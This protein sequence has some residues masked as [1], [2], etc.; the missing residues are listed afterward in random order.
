MTTYLIRRLLQGILILFIVTVLVFVVMRLLP[1]DPLSLYVSQKDIGQ[2]T[3]EQIEELHH[4]FGLDKPIPM[5]Y[6]SWINGVF[7]GDLG[8]SIY[9]NQQRVSY[10]ISSRLPITIHIGVIS[11]IITSV[12]GVL[13]GIVCALRRGGWIDNVVTF[14]A[15]V[16]ITVPTFWVGILLIYF[17]AMQLKWLPTTGY[18]S[19]FD[20]FWLGTKQLIMPVFCLSIPGIAGLTRQ[21]RSS[22]LEVVMQDYV[23]TAWAK[24]L[25]E[26]I[27]VLRHEVKNALIPVIT[28]LGMQVG[29]IFGGSV[30]IETVYNIP[31]MGRLL[32]QAVF[33]HDFQ[34]VQA[35]T[36]MVALIVVASNLIVDI[37]YGWFDPRIRYN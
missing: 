3:A 21:T 32:T 7:H 37:S 31:G 20:D 34:I 22:M 14:I 15:N 35:G 4:K 1:G 16:G 8:T 17:F 2:L 10:L 28:I 27:I 6:I 26:R 9:Y 29:G 13:F 23:R 5:Q 11:F 25:H 30:L 33:A 24:G 36:L 12:L 18:T 19:P